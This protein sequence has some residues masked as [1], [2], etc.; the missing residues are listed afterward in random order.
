MRAVRG[1]KKKLIV[2]FHFQYAN[3]A[4]WKCDDCRRNGLEKRRR[5]GWLNHETA[6]PE[7]VIWARRQVSLTSCPKSF[8]TPQSLALL[9]EYAVWRRLGNRTIDGLGARQV[10][11]FLI[12]DDEVSKERAQSG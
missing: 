1:G 8:I 2:A 7:R 5:C 10:E 9:E 4:G 3:Q 6:G 11:A 12:L